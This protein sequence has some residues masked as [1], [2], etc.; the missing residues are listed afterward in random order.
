MKQNQDGQPALSDVATLRKRAR[1]DIASGAVT[2]GYG[3]DRETVLR[4]LNEA[5]AT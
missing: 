1:Q 2:A 3:A 5:L 4:L